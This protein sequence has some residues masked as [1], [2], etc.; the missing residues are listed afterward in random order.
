MCN[1]APTGWI[2]IEKEKE[3]ERIEVSQFPCDKA[4]YRKLLFQHWRTMRQRM[5]VWFITSVFFV[6]TPSVLR[7]PVICLLGSRLYVLGITVSAWYE[8]STGVRRLIIS[9]AGRGWDLSS[10]A[11]K[12]KYRR[13]RSAISLDVCLVY[14]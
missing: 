9:R 13:S 14:F 12:Q 6:F 10:T 4:Q 7:V 2:C 5:K 11:R 8:K 1:K 3:R